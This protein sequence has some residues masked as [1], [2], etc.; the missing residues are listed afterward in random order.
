MEQKSLYNFFQIIASS[1]SECG[2]LA[3]SEDRE[4]NCNYINVLHKIK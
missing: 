1:A 3:E 4:D 2:E